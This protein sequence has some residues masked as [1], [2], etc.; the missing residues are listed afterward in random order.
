MGQVNGLAVALVPEHAFGYPVR[1]TASVAPGRGEL[2]DL[3]REAE[4]S[5]PIHT[6]GFMILAGFLREHYAV[7]APLAL[8]A[9][10]VFEQSYATVEGDSAS[11]AE[12]YA[13]LSALAGEPIRQGI[14]V[15]GSIDQRGRIQLHARA[16]ERLV[17]LGEAARRALAADLDGEP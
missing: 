10:L 7:D 8:R 6:K 11:S 4:L 1:I 16:H 3:D 9:S 12:L 17:Q 5:G 2:V 13:L 14:A 15:T